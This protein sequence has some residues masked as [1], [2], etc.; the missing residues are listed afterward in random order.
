MRRR[1]YSLIVFLI[2]A[3]VLLVLNLLHRTTRTTLTVPGTLNTYAMG[4]TEDYHQY[5]YI[6]KRGMEGHILYHNAYSEEN[7]PDVLL[8]PFYHITGILSAP[9][10]I[11]PYD[12]YFLLH[13]I[14]LIVLLS[15]IYRLICHI[16]KTETGRSVAFVLFVSATGI[17]TLA[18]L[19]PFAAV[20]QYLPDYNFDLFMKYHVMQPHHDIATALYIIAIMALSERVYTWR[21]ILVGG[22]AAAVL[23]FIHP[24]I[25]L[26]L[27]FTLIVEHIGRLLLMKREYWKEAFRYVAPIIIAIPT[28]A[29]TYY[30]LVYVLQFEIGL[31][32]IV[33]HLP[34]QQTFWSYAISLGPLLFTSLF[35]VFHIKKIIEAPILRCIAI[36]AYLPLILFFLPDYQIPINTWRLFQTYQ[37]IPMAILTAY[38]L[39]SWAKSWPILARSAPLITLCFFLYGGGI[40]VQAY[41]EAIRPPDRLVWTVD[42]PHVVIS[43]FDYL[44]GSSKP[45]SVVLGGGQLSNLVP[46]F[47]HNRVIIGHNGDNRNFLFKQGEINNFLMGNTP[48]SD[49][50][51]FLSRYG[52]AYIVFGIDAPFFHNTPYA[53]LSFLNEVYVEPKTGF[54]VV[55]VLSDK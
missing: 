36:W 22:L 39:V 23:G 50:R 14:S 37:H 5:M 9:F 45:D 48:E 47:T 35:C 34:R 44:K 13:L 30:T 54:S 52:V 28:A 1:S 19:H 42:V 41:Q 38:T 25:Q 12:V 24:Y 6:I 55:Q 20:R 4:N 32:G 49:V 3:A 11:S 51:D 21:R 40:Y 29:I 27:F 26:F 31:K 16:L 18:S 33:T 8:Q 17:W 7:I 10:D 53:S 2:L 43:L 46:E 15:C